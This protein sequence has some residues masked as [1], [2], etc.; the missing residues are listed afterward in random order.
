MYMNIVRSITM[1]GTS[2]VRVIYLLLILSY[3][4]TVMM[5]FYFESD[6]YFED[7]GTGEN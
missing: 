6:W 5:F 3:G 2:L 7:I 4:F 1:N